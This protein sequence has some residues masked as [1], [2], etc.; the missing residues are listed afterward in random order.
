MNG[1]A[2]FWKVVP[3][4]DGKYWASDLGRVRKKRILKL[5]RSRYGLLKCIINGREAYVRDVVY[6][7][8]VG[9]ID[10]GRYVEHLDGDCDNFTPSNLFICRKA[11]LASVT[12][13]IDSSEEVWLP[14]SGFPG[15][16]ASSHGK[17][18]HDVRGLLAANSNAQYPIVNMRNASG[19]VKTVFV[20]ICILT[21]FRGPPGPGMVCRH[22]DGNSV[23]DCVLNLEWG[24][25]RQN[26]ADRQ[27]HNKSSLL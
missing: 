25:K 8:W 4:T 11:T 1:T 2:E 24:T 10:A 9:P 5:R 16:R 15:Y 17:I 23:N 26:S 13:I 3:G 7:A 12:S 22:L 6:S 20:H 21:T 14:I 27:I 18:T 19:V